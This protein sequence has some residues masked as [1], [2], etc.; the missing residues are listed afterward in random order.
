M[1]NK[2]DLSYC[3]HLTVSCLLNTIVC[4]Q[5]KELAKKLPL[6]HNEIQEVFSC[7]HK[8]AL[9]VHHTR[10][11]ETGPFTRESMVTFGNHK[12]NH[13]SNCI[14]AIFLRVGIEVHLVAPSELKSGVFFLT[15]NNNIL[16]T[17]IN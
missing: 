16:G 1:S 15:L 3:N 4:Q 14:L 2:M 8:Q 13:E 6:A 11:L 17:K 7:F 12:S 9:S 10:A 5:G